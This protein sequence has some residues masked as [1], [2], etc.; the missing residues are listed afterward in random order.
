[1]HARDL[2]LLPLAFALAAWPARAQ[3]TGNADGFD[4]V[5]CEAGE[6]EHT[7]P[8]L[9]KPA[10]PRHSDVPVEPAVPD[11]ACAASHSHAVK[12]AAGAPINGRVTV[13]FVVHSDGSVHDV[14][15]VGEAEGALFA[16]ARDCLLACRF[17]PAKALRRPLAVRMTQAFS[18]RTERKAGPAP[19]RSPTAPAPDGTRALGAIVQTFTFQP[20]Q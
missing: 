4:S 3:I 14:A 7:P 12:D 6:C 5:G 11:A 10:E 16:A 20:S 13:G 9:E 17:T 19:T 1:M 15:P 2:A 18:F 8:E